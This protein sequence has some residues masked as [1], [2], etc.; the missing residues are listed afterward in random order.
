VETEVL[1][2]YCMQQQ[3]T[4]RLQRNAKVRA[5]RSSGAA[6]TAYLVK[7]TQTHPIS[8]LDMINPSKS[9]SSSTETRPVPGIH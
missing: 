4:V 2:F 5:G 7:V 8:W 9:P 1:Y 6:C 3:T